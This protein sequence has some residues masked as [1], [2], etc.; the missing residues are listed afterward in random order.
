ML[1]STADHATKPKSDEEK[2]VQIQRVETASFTRVTKHSRSVNTKQIYLLLGQNGQVLGVLQKRTS[3][4]EKKFYRY[5]YT[6]D[7]HV[8]QMKSTHEEKGMAKIKF[9]NVQQT[10]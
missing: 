6:F 4:L 2:Y 7:P 5:N 1:I 10:R 9:I 8:K 3:S